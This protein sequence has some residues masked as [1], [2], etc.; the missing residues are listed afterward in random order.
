MHD[1]ILNLIILEIK[2]I[3]KLVLKF[4]KCMEVKYDKS[5][6]VVITIINKLELLYSLSKFVIGEMELTCSAR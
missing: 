5:I 2:K 6:L 1:I 4:N 3:K